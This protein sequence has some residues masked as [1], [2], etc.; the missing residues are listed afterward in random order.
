MALPIPGLNG[1]SEYSILRG[2]TRADIRREPYAHIVA[3]GCL[4][5]RL[6][7]ELSRTFPADET[8]LRL[9]KS[10]KRARR[11]SRHDV[12]ARCILRN[13]DCFSQSWRDFVSYHVSD[14][15]FQEFVRLMGPEILA[16]YPERPAET[17]RYSN[18]S[19]TKLDCLSVRKSS[20]QMP[21]RATP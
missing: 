9:E 16:A 14:G 17:W 5:A 8:I 2:I 15:F 1:M 11:N 4:P 13:P 3:E 18:R 21:S 10:G 6:Y 19:A 7:A 12:G 20:N